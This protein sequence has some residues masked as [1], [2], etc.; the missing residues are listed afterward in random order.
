MTLAAALPR[1]GRL[2]RST[3]RSRD[4]GALNWV[5]LAR[6]VRGRLLSLREEDYALAARGAGA[7]DWRIIVVHLLPGFTSHLIV[8]ITFIIPPMILN[9]TALSFLG[10]GMQ[11]PAVSWGV[12]LQDSRNIL[13]VAHTP[14]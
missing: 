1:N 5:G 6:V 11:P 8:S 10:M 12:L 13:A 7:S 9:E 14:G 3:L 4:H 2:S